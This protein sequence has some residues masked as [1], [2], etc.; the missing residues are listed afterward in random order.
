MLLFLLYQTN[1]AFENIGDFFKKH[2]K[3]SHFWTAVYV[4]A[5]KNAKLQQTIHKKTHNCIIKYCI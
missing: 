4:N 3:K 2:L 5:N 1:V